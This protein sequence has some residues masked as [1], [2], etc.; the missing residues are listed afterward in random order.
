MK[1][2]WVTVGS[3]GTL[4]E[5]EMARNRLEVDGI[6][7]QLSDGEAGFGGTL[8]GVKLLVI[9]EDAQRAESVLNRV[10]KRARG[11]RGDDY[12]LE[13]TVTDKPG[14]VRVEPEEKEPAEDDAGDEIEVSG[15]DKAAMLAWRVAVVG[16]FCPG[17]LHVFALFLL[18]QV[19]EAEGE[20]TPTGNNCVLGTLVVSVLA[21]LV[22]VGLV[23]GMYTIR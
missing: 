11:K 22:L 2:S 13:E 20:L 9:E 19:G 5:A 17:F 12:G 10:R 15:K 1:D 23:V 4:A 18:T 3:F 7:S 8:G 6:E 14:K 16:L 21:F